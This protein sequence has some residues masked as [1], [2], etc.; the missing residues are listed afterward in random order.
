MTLSPT[1]EAM[2][3]AAR[4]KLHRQIEERAQ[5][6]L[7]RPPGTVARSLG[8]LYGARERMEREY[9]EACCRG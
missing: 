2:C 9:M 4:K 7:G 3:A 5:L 8:Q 6:A 1:I